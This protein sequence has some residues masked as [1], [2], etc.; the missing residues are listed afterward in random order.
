VQGRD[1]TG[2]RAT[3]SLRDVARDSKRGKATPQELFDAF[4]AATLYWPEPKV[5]GL[6]VIRIRGDLVAPVFSSEAELIKVSGGGKWLSACGLDV[7]SLMP[8]GVTIGLDI[9][10][11]HRLQLDPSAVRIA[12]ELEM[13][14]LAAE[15][16]AAAQDDEEEG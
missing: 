7:L 5:Q 15:P 1:A 12:Y 2:P 9:G 8:E 13:R 4:V 10:S 6:P 14:Q 11:D 16:E 3:R